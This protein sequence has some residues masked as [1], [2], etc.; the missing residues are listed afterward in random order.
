MKKVLFGGAFD[1]FHYGHLLAIKKAKSYGDYLIVN[2]MS[3]ERCKLKKGKDRP[4]IPAEER[5]KLIEALRDVDEVNCLY[6]DPEFPTLK[7]VEKLRP[8]VLVIDAINHPYESELKKRCQELGIQFVQID[9]IVTKSGLD[10]SN[11]IKKI[12]KI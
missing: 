2:V 11:I 10:T 7:L 8:D 4:I 1:L 6:G 9:R 3:D 5:V 12:N